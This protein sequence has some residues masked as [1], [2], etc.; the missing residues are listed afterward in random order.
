MTTIYET[1]NNPMRKEINKMRKG[2]KLFFYVV[3]AVLC[4]ASRLVFAGEPGPYQSL[5]DKL[6]EKG[7][8]S[9][10]ERQDLLTEASDEKKHKLPKVK[11]SGYLQV[12]YT[13]TQDDARVEDDHYL[14]D[15]Y[16]DLNGFAV[17]R[18]RLTF[19]GNIM[20]DLGFKLSGDFSTANDYK[21]KDTK[22]SLKDAYVSYN[23]CSYGQLKA[24][25]FKVPFGRE[26]TT[27]SSLILTPNRALVVNALS[28][29]RDIGIE[30]SGK[31][32]NQMLYYALGIFNGAGNNRGNN[33]DQ[34][35]FVG[36]LAGS[37]PKDFALGGEPF[38]FSLGGSLLHNQV[39]EGYKYSF[40]FSCSVGSILGACLDM[41]LL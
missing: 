12:R 34:T 18:G 28:P 15:R 41:Y 37:S 2:R 23:R 6:T 39:E 14:D 21:N 20:A 7:V 16:T 13:A 36:R 32:F 38:L 33:N 19:S 10:T 24:G 35:M 9:D 30:L 25:Q 3:L 29:N 27:S 5:L 31:P 17:R 8:L 1:I 40:L 4:A 11:V 26:W 22:F